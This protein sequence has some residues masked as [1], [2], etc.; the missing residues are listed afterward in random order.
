MKKM[1][2]VTLPASVQFILGPFFLLPAILK[3]ATRCPHTF[4]SFPDSWPHL[5]CFLISSHYIQCTSLFPQAL[6]PIVKLLWTFQPACL[7]RPPASFA[8]YLFY[9]PACNWPLPA[10][11]LFMLFV[12]ACFSLPFVSIYL[13]GLS[14]PPQCNCLPSEGAVFESSCTLYFLHRSWNIKWPSLHQRN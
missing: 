13:P 9:L 8:F 5:T 1:F 12:P 11:A 4:P 10:H 2:T 6:C 7:F 14:V 3:P